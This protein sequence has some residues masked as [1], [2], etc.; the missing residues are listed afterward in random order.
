MDWRWDRRRLRVLRGGY[1][2]KP[3]PW[4]TLELFSL[5]VC[6]RSFWIK[7]KTTPPWPVSWMGAL[8][9]QP[10]HRRS[11]FLDSLTTSVCASPHLWSRGGLW[12]ASL[13]L[14]PTLQGSLEVC[15]MS[16][17]VWGHMHI[18]SLLATVSMH[19]RVLY[20][21]QWYCSLTLWLLTKMSYFQILFVFY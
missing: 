21:G 18:Q 17:G 15:T 20:T 3:H 7:Y 11:I 10:L 5:W 6:F 14:T 8:S 1:W 12:W 16:K 9:A 19:I 13:P 2:Q 4:R